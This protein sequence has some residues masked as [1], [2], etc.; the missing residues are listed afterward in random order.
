[1]TRQARQRSTTDQLLRVL[2]RTLLTVFGVQVLLAVSLP[3]VDSYRRRNRKPK[4]FPTTAPIEVTVGRGSVTTYTFGQDL[5]DDMLAAIEGA[6][7][8]GSRRRH[9]FSRHRSAS[10]R[11]AH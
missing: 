6:R 1:V 9:L 11:A 2:R 4:P 5:Y 10:I 3:L 8:V 7:R